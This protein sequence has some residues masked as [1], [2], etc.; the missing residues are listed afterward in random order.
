MRYT[1][2]E[3]G[4]KQDIYIPESGDKI[5]DRDLAQA[6]IEKTKDQLRRKQIKASPKASKS[7]ISGV[8]REVNEFMNRQKS[9]HK[10]KFY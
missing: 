4:L 8:L 3:N 7:D 1:V 10:R 2:K 5:Y 9:D 6:Y